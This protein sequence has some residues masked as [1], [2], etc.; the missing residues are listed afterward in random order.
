MSPPRS[1]TLTYCAG[2][3]IKRKSVCLCKCETSYLIVFFII[4]LLFLLLGFFAMPSLRAPRVVVISK[5]CVV[6]VGAFS[7]FFPSPSQKS[8]AARVAQT[9]SPRSFPPLH[10]FLRPTRGA[11][12]LASSMLLRVRLRLRHHPRL[13]VV[14]PKP[15]YVRFDILHPKLSTSRKCHS[16]FRYIQK[17]CIRVHHTRTRTHAHT[18]T[19]YS[20][21]W[22]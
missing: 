22:W 12:F 4:I 10:R 21:R 8:H 20:M 17:C 3:P 9:F 2:T 16:A 14:S 11:R 5:V 7:F 1:V 13:V 6:L 15:H 18:H 19:H